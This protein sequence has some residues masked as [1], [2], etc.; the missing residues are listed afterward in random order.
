V[1]V[2]VDT[3]TELDTGVDACVVPGEE[4]PFPEQDMNTREIKTRM[5]IKRN[6]LRDTFMTSSFFLGTLLCTGK[7]R[8]I[9]LRTRESDGVVI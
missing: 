2:V 6:G 5:E 1:D 9:S 3:G 8:Y 7:S 4:E